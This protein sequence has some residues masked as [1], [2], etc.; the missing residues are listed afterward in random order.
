MPRGDLEVIHPRSLTLKIVVRLLETGE[1]YGEAMEILRRQRINQNIV[2]DNNP[3]LF[4]ANVRKFLHQ[5]TDVH[6]LSLFIAD[7]TNDDTSRSMYKSMFQ[8]W[9]QTQFPLCL[10]YPTCVTL[11]IQCIKA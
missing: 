3:A 10:R 1:N 4:I 9:S 7:L 6:R 5:V 8:V 2:V 11:R